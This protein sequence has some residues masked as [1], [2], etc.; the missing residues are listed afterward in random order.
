MQIDLKHY[1]AVMPLP[2]HFREAT[3]REVDCTQYLR[4]FITTVPT[5]SGQANYIRRLSGRAFT[6]QATPD[7]LTAFT[8]APGQTCF[9][10]HYVRIERDPH[11]LIDR[12]PVPGM[13]WVDDFGEHQIRMKERVEEVG[14]HG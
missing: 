4:G 1:R 7:G 8:F 14:G 11:F 3:C 6:E 5:E 12:R 10:T 13:T 9:R 2:T